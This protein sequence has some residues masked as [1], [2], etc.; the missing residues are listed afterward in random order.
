M[1]RSR[2]RR[3]G[4]PCKSLMYFK[5]TS[6][7]AR[8]GHHGHRS[9]TSDPN[10]FP[11]GYRGSVQIFNEFANPHIGIVFKKAKQ[12]TVLAHQ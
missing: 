10:D 2:C 9:F 7:N 4:E 8:F 3:S 5:W 6:R 11:E 1:S 12:S